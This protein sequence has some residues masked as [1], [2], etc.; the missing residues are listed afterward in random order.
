MYTPIDKS[1]FDAPVL[2]LAK[3]LIGQYIVHEL[4]EGTIVV[5]IVETEAYQGPED[6]AAHSFDNRRTKRTEVMFGLA[7]LVYTYQMHTH[8]L[9]NVVG[10][11]VGT[12]HAILIRAAEPVTGFERMKE[13]RGAH[14][15]MKDWTNGPGKLTKA[16]G[17]T[18]QYY[19]HHWTERPLF[20]AEGAVPAEI[21]TGPRVGIGNSGEAVHYPW[22][23]YEKDNPYVSKYRP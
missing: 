8:T 18:M 3:K 2:E 1:F 21:I 14:L 11:A 16:L 13:N 7:G 5:R 6:Q 12:P 19:G 9:M 15:K 20:I 22:R 10:G 23:F 17:V 4:L